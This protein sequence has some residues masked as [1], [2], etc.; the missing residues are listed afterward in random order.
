MINELKVVVTCPYCGQE[1][2]CTI[3]CFYPGDKIIWCPVESK[4]CDRQFAIRILL[5]PKIQVS[6]L[7]WQLKK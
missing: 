7:D 3:N 1:S 5:K 6:K 4:G 2:L